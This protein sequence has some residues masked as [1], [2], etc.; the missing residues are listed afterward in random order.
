MFMFYDFANYII[1][2]VLLN[3][4]QVGNLW[5]SQ[6]CQPARIITAVNGQLPGP[7]INAEEGDTVVVH[8]VNRSP[9]NM[10]IHW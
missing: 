6:L 5:I 8:L 1:F 2:H 3:Y 9:Y 10:T 4:Y 7:M